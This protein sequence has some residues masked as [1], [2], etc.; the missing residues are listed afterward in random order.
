MLINQS[1]VLIFYDHAEIIE[2][3]DE[4]LDLF[5]RDQ[6]NDYDNPLLPHPVE[7]LI[8]NIDLILNHY[9]LPIHLWL[10]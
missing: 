7:K 4:P 10:P 2:T 9:G 1:F 3:G 8:L 5:A 6:F